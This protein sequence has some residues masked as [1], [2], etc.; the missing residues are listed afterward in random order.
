[1]TEHILVTLFSC[2]QNH[3]LNIQ[4]TELIH[5]VGDEVKALLV[6][7]TGNHADHKLLVVLLKTQLFLKSLF[8]FHFFLAEILDV[9]VFSNKSIRLRIVLIVI[10]S[11]YD[12]AEVIG[13]GIEKAVQMLSVERC[14][15]LLRIGSTHGSN[16]IC[17]DQSAL[18]IVG[19]SVGFQFI[20]CEIV[21][22]KSCDIPHRF[23]IPDALKFQVMYGHDRFDPTVKLVVAELI[24]Q[25]N[26][27]QTRLPVMAV[28]DVRTEVHIRQDR[29]SCL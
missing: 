12:S 4:L 22:R 1:M 19:I 25:E 20:R 21:S 18:E 13:T 7:Q 5:H 8:V 10:D 27:N 2:S 26:R 24:F 14:L 15:D 17:I 23:H 29:E 6:C 11:V 16:R 3:Q 9:I 28:D